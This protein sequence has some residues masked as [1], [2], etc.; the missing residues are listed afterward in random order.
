VTRLLTITALAFMALTAPPAASD[1]RLAEQYWGAEAC[2]GNVA[3]IFSPDTLD[4]GEWGRAGACA[5]YVGHTYMAAE[6]VERCAVEV[7]EYGH[8]LGHDHDY[9]AD[10]EGVML[11]RDG[12][13]GRYIATAGICERMQP[14]SIQQ[15]AAA[16]DSAPVPPDAEA[17]DAYYAA[18]DRYDDARERRADCKYA[19]KHRRTKRARRRAL[20]RCARVIV[21]PPRPHAPPDE[22][23]DPVHPPARA[24]EA[25]TH[26]D[27]TLIPAQPRSFALDGPTPGALR[28]AQE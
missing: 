8:L 4:T 1:L 19:A 14:P 26:R 3:I 28:V 10:P 11:Y 21:T 7:H 5:L 24:T 2:G 13:D 9:A 25:A 22:Q 20:R 18:L 27:G 15:P 6:P 12:P 23:P 16:P 17:A